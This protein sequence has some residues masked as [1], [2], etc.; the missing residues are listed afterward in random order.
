MSERLLGLG[1][2]SKGAG[3]W[4]ATFYGN[5]TEAFLPRSSPNA[6]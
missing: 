2:T 4:E 5:S 3:L 6:C 1:L